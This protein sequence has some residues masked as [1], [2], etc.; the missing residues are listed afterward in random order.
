MD[1]GDN[2]QAYREAVNMLNKLQRVA[3][4]EA[5]LAGRQHGRIRDVVKDQNFTDCYT[6]PTTRWHFVTTVMTSWGLEEAD[7]FLTQRLSASR[8]LYSMERVT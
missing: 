1:G 6:K 3:D 5:A 2:L 4:S 8:G 7:K